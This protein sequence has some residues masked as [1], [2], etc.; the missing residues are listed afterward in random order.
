MAFIAIFIAAI[1]VWLG[2]RVL[3]KAGI[4]GFWALTVVIPLINIAMVWV[5][6][7]SRWPA[8]DQAPPPP[9]PTN[10]SFTR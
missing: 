10:N 7:F 1:Y 6:A 5:F 4:P 9:A 8:V 3:Q 2:F